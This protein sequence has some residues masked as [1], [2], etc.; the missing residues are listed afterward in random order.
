[1]L[2]T[3]LDSFELQNRAWS[4]EID[5]T[6]ESARHLA[7]YNQVQKNV[8]VARAFYEL[9]CIVQSVVN[10]QLGR[11]LHESLMKNATTQSKQNVIPCQSQFSR[12]CQSF[13]SGRE[14]CS[15]KWGRP[16]SFNGMSFCNWLFFS[17]RIIRRCPSYALCA[18][19]T[20][21]EAW[22]RQLDR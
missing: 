9:V 5:R 10:S 13:N 2:K 15:G 20:Q 4:Q 7:K 16:S 17:I 1:M 6:T 19:Q 21:C 8:R 12:S 3:H 14:N 11:R 18:P 22:D